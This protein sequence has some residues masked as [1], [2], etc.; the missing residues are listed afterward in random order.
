VVR[1][2]PRLV[3]GLELLAWIVAGADGDPPHPDAVMRLTT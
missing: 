2:G 1:P 3:D